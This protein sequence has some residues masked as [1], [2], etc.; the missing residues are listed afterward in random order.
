MIKYIYIES[1]TLTR[2]RTRS[3]NLISNQKTKENS[4]KD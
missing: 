3:P 2:I 4:I 1:L